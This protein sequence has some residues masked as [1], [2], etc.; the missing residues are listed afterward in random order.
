MLATIEAL[1][2]EDA[3]KRDAIALAPSRS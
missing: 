2:V 1:L 3:V